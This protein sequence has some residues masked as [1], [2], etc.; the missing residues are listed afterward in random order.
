MACED[1]R[2]PLS[3]Y[4]KVLKKAGVTWIAF[5]CLILLNLGVV[6][7]SSL[8]AGSMRRGEAVLVGGVF[9]G[10][11]IGF[12]AGVF[13]H[14]GVQS[15]SGTARDTLGNGIGSIIFGGLH[16]GGGILSVVSE[17]TIQAGVD[18]LAGIGLLV[19]GVMALLCRSEYRTWRKARKSL[20]NGAPRSAS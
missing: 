3:D 20:R 8:I 16:E 9:G 11:F 18:F 5:G 6:F 12:V 7:L 15:I 13:I 19:A 4:P 10:L 1:D 14:V 2:V 17:N